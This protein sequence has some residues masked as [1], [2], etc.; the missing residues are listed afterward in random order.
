MTLPTD[1]LLSFLNSRYSGGPF[2]LES[3]LATAGQRAAYRL[4]GASGRFVAKRSEPGRDPAIVERDA[5]TLEFL[6]EQGLA[7]PPP[8]RDRAGALVLPYED[9]LV[10][11]YRYIEG[12]E[13]RVD[14]SL[15]PRLGALMAGLHSLP[16]GGRVPI[17]AYRPPAILSQVR[18]FIESVLRQSDLPGQRAAAADVLEMMERFP[19]FE[20]L[21]E[22]I[23][24][25]DPYF[26]NLL[27]GKDGR[28]YLIDWDDGGIS[29]PLMDVGY[30]LV[31]Q[32]TFLPHDRVNLRMPGPLTGITYQPAWGEAF[33]HAYESIRPLTADER[34]LLPWAMRLAVIAYLPLWEEGILILDNYERMKLALGGIRE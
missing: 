8:V 10:Y 28:L 21:P 18:P 23:I 2:I 15:Y 27:D 30:I 5:G 4:R 20:G 25:T 33:L 22:G 34:R 11:L 9:C 6:A 29:Y 12:Q 13:P 7:V 1:S 3:T 24:H 31:H 19:S 14:A 32:T 16:T 17:S 26:S